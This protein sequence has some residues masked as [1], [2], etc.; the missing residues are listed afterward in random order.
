MENEIIELLKPIILEKA[1]KMLD[2]LILFLLEEIKKVETSNAN[3]YASISF[4]K[5][6]KDAETLIIAVQKTKALEKK[7]GC[8]T[9]EIENKK[10]LTAESLKNLLVNSISNNPD[11]IAKIIEKNTEE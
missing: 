10:I 1:P 4:L 11:V 3:E 6:P 9:A 5:N 7:Q 8:F 2:A